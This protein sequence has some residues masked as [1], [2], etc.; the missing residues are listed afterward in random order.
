MFVLAVPNGVNL[1]PD[2]G[3][4]GE[5]ET[6]HVGV[7]SDKEESHVQAEQ[8]ERSSGHPPS[9]SLLL[10]RQ[11]QKRTSPTVRPWCFPRPFPEVM[12]DGMRARQITRIHGTAA[13]ELGV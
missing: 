3:E 6:N 1:I 10:Y 13:V 11:F 7:V 4:I 5:R 9:P 12:S 8:S 2:T